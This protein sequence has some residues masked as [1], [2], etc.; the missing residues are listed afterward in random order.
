ML[1]SLQ[2]H[3][4]NIFDKYVPGPKPSRLLAIALGLYL[5]E[6]RW[7]RGDR[8]G[9]RLGTAECL[10][11]GCCKNL[12]TNLQT[13]IYFSLFWRPGSPR[14]GYQGARRSGA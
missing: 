1:I 13:N 7:H 8:L 10:N 11:S 3:H 4:R 9:D 2:N 5:S 6:S 14:P 12:Q